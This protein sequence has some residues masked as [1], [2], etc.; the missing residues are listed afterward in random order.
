MPVEFTPRPAQARILEYTDGPMGVSAVPGSGKTFTL[1]LLASQLVE[2]LATTG[3]LDDREILI[4]TFTNSAV[5]NFRS[6]IGAFLREEVATADWA[7]HGHRRIHC[8]QVRLY[9]L[10]MHM[11]VHLCVHVRTVRNACYATVLK[12][13]VAV[14]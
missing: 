12:I 5:A 1:S 7:R 6:R 13:V 3:Q 11:R 9:V 2:R 4:V 8:N 10:T 14:I